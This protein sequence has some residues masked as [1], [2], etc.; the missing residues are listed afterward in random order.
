MEALNNKPGSLQ[1]TVLMTIN[2]QVTKTFDYIVPINLPHIFRGS[3]LIPGIETTSIQEG[4]NTAGLSRTIF[5]KDGT[6]SQETLLTVVRPNSFSYKNDHFTSP[7]LKRLVKR[8]E[9]EWVFTELETNQTR[10]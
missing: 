4:W 7:I 9:G 1:T 3:L 10:V 6:S 2:A 5:F 8:L